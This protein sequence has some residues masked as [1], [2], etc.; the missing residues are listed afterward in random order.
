MQSNQRYV[1]AVFGALQGAMALLAL[2]STAVTAYLVRFWIEVLSICDAQA[3]FPALRVGTLLLAE[4]GFLTALGTFIR[5]CGHLKRNSAF[6]EA[7]DRMLCTIART[8]AVGAVALV[9]GAL[10]L[11]FCLLATS[12]LYSN[13]WQNMA[14]LLLPDM[15]IAFVMLGVSLVARVL[16]ELLCRAIAIQD[17]QDA[18]I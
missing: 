18:T 16:Q 7:N 4:G 10:A 9:S 17:E 6:T 15:G 2:L 11:T 14:L 12:S 13:L 8:M 3:T 1:A 5:M